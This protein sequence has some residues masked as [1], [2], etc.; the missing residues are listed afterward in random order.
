M[1]CPAPSWTQKAFMSVGKLQH[2]DPTNSVLTYKAEPGSDI[3]SEMLNICS[4][5]RI[6]DPL[7]LLFL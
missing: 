1:S 5:C 7:P 4:S 2:H 3:F 6:V